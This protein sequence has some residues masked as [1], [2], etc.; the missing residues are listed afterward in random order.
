[1]IL[2]ICPLFLLMFPAINDGDLL[3]FIASGEQERN[4]L[5]DRLHAG[6]NVVCRS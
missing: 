2:G 4:S 6:I 5:Q 1:M 3:D